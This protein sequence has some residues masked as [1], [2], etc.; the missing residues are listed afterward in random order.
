[1]YVCDSSSFQYHSSSLSGLI[2]T[3]FRS[4]KK[5]FTKYIFLPFELFSPPSNHPYPLIIVP[6]FPID[7]MYHLSTQSLKTVLDIL[8]LGNFHLTSIESHSIIIEP[9]ITT[10]LPAFLM[11]HILILKL[12]E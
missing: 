12:F 3:L 2:E 4:I 8:L 1:M 9:I 6:I 7:P 10:T 5:S 11:N